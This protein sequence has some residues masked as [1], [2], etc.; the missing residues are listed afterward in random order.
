MRDKIRHPAGVDI[1]GAGVLRHGIFPEIAL[2]SLP[3]WTLP[4][5]KNLDRPDSAVYSQRVRLHGG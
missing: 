1:V 3:E 5:G 4:A 2:M